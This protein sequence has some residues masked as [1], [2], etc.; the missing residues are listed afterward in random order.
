[1]KVN[2]GRNSKNQLLLPDNL[3]IYYKIYYFNSHMQKN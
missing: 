1:M 2:N 3:S